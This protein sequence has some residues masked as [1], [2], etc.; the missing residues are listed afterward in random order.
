MSLTGYCTDGWTDTPD[1]IGPS[2]L[3]HGSNKIVEL[4]VIILFSIIPVPYG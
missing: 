4:K 2:P 3:M 1:S